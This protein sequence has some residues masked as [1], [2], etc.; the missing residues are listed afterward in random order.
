MYLSNN[1]KK[2]CQ[3]H[4]IAIKLHKNVISIIGEIVEYLQKEEIYLLMSCIANI[5]TPSLP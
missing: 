5:T 2:S 3:I 4:H 1:D